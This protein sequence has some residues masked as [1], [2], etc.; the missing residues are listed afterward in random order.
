MQNSKLLKILRQLNDAERTQLKKFVRSPYFNESKAVT[1]LVEFVLPLLHEKEEEK[2]AKEKL[3][4]H[5]YPHNEYKEGKVN[6]LMKIT[7]E[8]VEKFIQVH[9][10]NLPEFRLDTEIFA[11]IRL[12]QF[13]LS[14]QNEKMALATLKNVQQLHEKSDYRNNQFFYRQF[15]IEEY[16]G[17][18][19][20]MDEAQHESLDLQRIIDNVQL[21]YL[22]TQLEY[23]CHIASQQHIINTNYDIDF[24]DD[25]LAYIA[26]NAKIQHIPALNIYYHTACM[27][28][29]PLQRS[30]FEQ[31]YQLIQQY[32]QLFPI[33]EKKN[34]YR[35]LRN[36]CAKRS[37][38]YF[39]EQLWD[40]YRISLE[41]SLLY[42]EWEYI[43]AITF[44]SIVILSLRLKKVDWV[45]NFLENYHPYLPQKAENE[46]YQY[47]RAKLY[48]AQKNY[49]HIV[50]IL[51][52]MDT[53]SSLSKIKKRRL[54]LQTYFELAKENQK[55]QYIYEELLD[56]NLKSFVKFLNDKKTI[57]T[58]YKEANKNFAYCLRKILTQ[59]PHSELQ[60]I[61][62]QIKPLMEKDWLLEKAEG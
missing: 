7:L 59:T 20:A 29:Y 52:S 13:Y 43:P 40:L 16:L 51:N 60:R 30:H 11:Q 54:L 55:E 57:S 27:L 34:L 37:G 9:T 12:T 38:R 41:S 58:H 49:T 25:I 48:F 23:Y 17:K 45:V 6:D 42:D 50:K 61:I 46:H 47:C 18:L 33:T 62:Q 19:P 2:L 53:K 4:T 15:L 1:T 22:L 36:Y 35:I 39:E 32:A 14:R 5:L 56:L 28:R 44:E 31:A 10:Q 8:L 26:K 3:F 21:F 24:F